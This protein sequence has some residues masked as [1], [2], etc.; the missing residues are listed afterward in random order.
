MIGSFHLLA[1]KTTTLWL[2]SELKKFQTRQEFK[3]IKASIRNGFQSLSEK[4]HTFSQFSSVL[5]RYNRHCVEGHSSLTSKLT[6]SLSCNLQ[7]GFEHA[8]HGVPKKNAIKKYSKMIINS[9]IFK[10]VRSNNSSIWNTW[11]KYLLQFAYILLKVKKSTPVSAGAPW[12]KPG[13]TPF[14]RPLAQLQIF[15]MPYF[16][17]IKMAQEWHVLFSELN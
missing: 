1:L 11:K 8:F 9:H 2:A 5:L 16:E 4:I 7:V 6:I 15:Q 17:K 12:P 13:R 3:R 14:T 10:W